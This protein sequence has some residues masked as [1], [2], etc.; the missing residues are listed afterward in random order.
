MG[1]ATSYR[2]VRCRLYP[3]P[4]QEAYFREMFRCCRVVYNH[5]LGVRVAAYEARR[6]DPGVRV[7]SRFDMCRML[8]A[9]KKTE[10][11]PEGRPYLRDVDSTALV[12][13]IKHLDDAFARLSRRV[14]SGRRAP[15]FPRPKGPGDRDSATVAFKRADFVER[16]RVRFA[17]IGWVRA[18]VWREPEGELVSCTVSVDAAGRWWASL[19]CKGVPDRALPPAAGVA[20]VRLGGSGAGGASGGDGDG[21]A[22]DGGPVDPDSPEAV[23]ERRAARRRRREERRLARRRG[24]GGEEGASKRYL[25]EAQ[26]A[27]LREARE[28]DRVRTQASQAAA[29]LVRGAGTVVLEGEPAGG[30]EEEL[31]RTLERKCAETGRGLVRRN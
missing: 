9:F 3:K 29:A 25:K 15:G 14:G 18:S 30:F 10:L 8:T 11:D 21:A 19:L 6:A 5:F 12:H 31:V 23:E 28:A 24:G 16:R 22:A 20:V 13:E 27:A 26:R 4:A 2:A 17:K 7:P 1:E